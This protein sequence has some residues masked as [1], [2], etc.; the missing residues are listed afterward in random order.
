MTM[1]DRE[2]GS[3]KRVYEAEIVV[4]KAPR[5]SYSSI[6]GRIKS[7]KRSTVEIKETAGTFAAKVRAADATALR[8]SV[9]ALMRD[10]Q[11][12]EGISRIK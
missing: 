8:A 6:M 1:P 12:I 9:N 2:G 4:S 10:I 3:S 7:Y 5:V 11:V